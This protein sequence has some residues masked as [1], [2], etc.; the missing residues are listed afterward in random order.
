MTKTSNFKS[1]FEFE[2]LL[3]GSRPRGLSQLHVLP[4][5]LV[6]DVKIF[7]LVSS[8]HQEVFIHLGVLGLDLT[9]LLV[10]QVGDAARVH[11]DCSLD[12][13]LLLIVLHRFLTTSGT[14]LSSMFISTSYSISSGFL[15]GSFFTLE[16][17]FLI[18]CVFL[19]AGITR[20][21]YR[22]TPL[23]K[24]KRQKSISQRRVVTET[25]PQEPSLP[26][27]KIEICFLKR[28][29]FLSLYFNLGFKDQLSLRAP[30]NI[31]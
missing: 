7:R 16:R 1:F 12:G 26:L 19:G 9:A 29:L 27:I 11:L 10:R 22:E 14:Q 4:V 21:N 15:L 18:L 8:T 24:D 31:R 13:S 23:P 20:F 28:V 5:F 6:E 2:G 3:H 25:S 17:P 30:F